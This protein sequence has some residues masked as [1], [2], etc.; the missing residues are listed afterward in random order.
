MQMQMQMQKNYYCFNGVSIVILLFFLLSK[1]KSLQRFKYVVF[2]TIEDYSGNY[3]S[4]W[5]LL[6]F[7]VNYFGKTK[8]SS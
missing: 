6:T 3:Y 2:K 4:E 1:D 8:F 7:Y 5:F